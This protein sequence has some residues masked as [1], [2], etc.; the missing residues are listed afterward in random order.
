[1]NENG[2][3]LGAVCIG[4]LIDDHRRPSNYRRRAPAAGFSVAKPMKS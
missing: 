4:Q 2:K 1:M 3:P